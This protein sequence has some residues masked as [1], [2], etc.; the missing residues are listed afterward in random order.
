[1]PRLPIAI[2]QRDHPTGRRLSSDYAIHAHE[3][4]NRSVSTITQRGV[5]SPRTKR[6]MPVWDTR[7]G[8]VSTHGALS[9]TIVRHPKGP[10]F[11][12]WSTVVYHSRTPVGASVQPRSPV[13]ASFRRRMR[14]SIFW[15][16]CRAEIS[17]SDLH[18]LRS[19]SPRSV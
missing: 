1:M 9:Y 4:L 14:K 16:A 17:L 15:L 13:G 2:Y 6:S 8:L 19:R 3:S 18:I 10:L 11:N 5:V 7:R 12:A